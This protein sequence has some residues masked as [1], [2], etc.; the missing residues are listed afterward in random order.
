MHGARKENNSD[1][2]GNAGKL[3]H[4]Y[5]LISLSQGRYDCKLLICRKSIKS[6]NQCILSSN[7]IFQFITIAHILV[8][9]A[10]FILFDLFADDQLTEVSFK[11]DMLI[12][13]VGN[14]NQVGLNLYYCFAGLLLFHQI[15]GVSIAQKPIKC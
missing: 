3:W 7:I 5:P 11:L 14:R 1:G 9:N 4:P 2:K 10:I 12:T 6:A 15:H 13:V 8:T